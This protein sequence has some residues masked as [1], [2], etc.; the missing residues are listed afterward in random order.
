LIMDHEK[1]LKE[2]KVSAPNA[3]ELV[4]EELNKSVQ[5]LMDFKFALD[6]SSIVAITDEKG[7]I[8]YVNDKFC[9]VSG[10]SSEE[11]LGKDHRILNSG[12]HNKEFFKEMWQ[13]IGTGSVWKGELRNKAKDGRYYWV[14]TTIVPFLK[15]NGKPYQYLAIRYE[16]TQRKRVEEELQQMMTKIM[17]V[18]EG[19]RKRLSRN[20]H[21]GIGQ[22]LYSHLITIQR[23]RAEMEHPLLE[24]MLAEAEELIEEVR[25]ISW[26][27]RPSVLDDLGLIPAIRSFLNRFSEHYKMDILFDCVLSG[28]LNY[29]V[30]TTIYRVIQESLTNIRKYAG[31]DE[32]AVTIREIDDNI[33]V[34][35]EDLGRGFASD[36]STRGVGLFSMEERAKSV[37]GNLQIYSEPEK[38]TKVILEVPKLNEG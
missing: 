14:D 36:R 2:D 7:K 32:A 17:D 28:R 33:R 24:Q 25:D 13:T 21:D 12:H 31:V 8:T 27:L 34:M 1:V 22:N 30:E 38:G 26:E 19:E 16:I 3:Y 4:V 11:L 5:E 15:E 9:D 18:Q 20:L 23:L 37:G 35:I 6:E 29:N 10:Y